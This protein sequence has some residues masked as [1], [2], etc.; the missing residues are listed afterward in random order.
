MGAHPGAPSRITRGGVTR[1]LTDGIGREG[2]RILGGDMTFS[3]MG[4][5]LPAKLDLTMDTNVT[6]K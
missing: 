6:V 5:E 3:I 4:M 2:R 1:S